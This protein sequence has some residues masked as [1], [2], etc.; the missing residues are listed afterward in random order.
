MAGKQILKNTIHLLV[1]RTF[2][3]GILLLYP[4]SRKS[5]SSVI[6]YVFH[7]AMN[8]YVVQDLMLVLNGWTQPIMTNVCAVIS[9]F[10]C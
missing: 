4:L 2:M 9:Q 1:D 6:V 8:K 10:T 7:L 5:L 3:T